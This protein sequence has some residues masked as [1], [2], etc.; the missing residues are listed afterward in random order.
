MKAFWFMVC[1]IAYVATGPISSSDVLCQVSGFFLTSSIEG[2]D[3]S[4]LIIAIH[5]ALCIFRHHKPGGETG[6]YPYRLYAY[7][8]W[9]IVPIILAS[10]VPLTGQRF[11]YNGLYCYLPVDPPWYRVG[12]SWIPRYIILGV[13][14]SVYGC[15][16]IY[17]GCRLRYLRRDQWQASRQNSIASH[18]N[19]L[20]QPPPSLL[21][22]STGRVITHVIRDR[23]QSVASD[24][25]FVKPN[26]S[27][28]LMTAVQP[29][30]VA[31]N[32][33]EPSHDGNRQISPKPQGPSSGPTSPT[34]V[35]FSPEAS[36][37]LLPPS[38]HLSSAH[39]ALTQS[40]PNDHPT[41]R[42]LGRRPLSLTSD[43]LDNAALTI[44]GVLHQSSPKASNFEHNLSSPSV[45]LI[46]PLTDEALLISRNK[47]RRQLRLLFIYPMIYVIAWVAP[48]V[49][50]IYRYGDAALLAQSYPLLMSTITSLCIGAAVDC[51]FFSAWEK[52]WR[53]L[54]GGFWEGLFMRFRIGRSRKN[55][56]RTREER[57]RDTM[58]AID[59][60]VQENA[61]RERTAALRNT[62]PARP[63]EWWDLEEEP[64]RASVAVSSV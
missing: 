12:L 38:T 59:R 15:V 6:L 24:V 51:C 18:K 43:E 26:D 25:S 47:T 2:A 29:E 4:V 42:P 22:Q 14:F 58:W 35:S 37:L 52:P 64:S 60:R 31:W 27:A 50:Q 49:S 57:L 40:A 41:W 62:R 8:F 45:H 54:Q 19:R 17:V 7:A 61:E 39:M 56:G 21:D 11:A 44:P 36:N 55:G 32:W 63:R 9:F 3:I 48:F 10:V 16:Y 53:Q 28:A 23:Q 13:I 34:R 30:D 5:S 20:S 33:S 46:E 1:P